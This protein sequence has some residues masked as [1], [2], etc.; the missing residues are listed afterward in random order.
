MRRPL[1]ALGLAILAA[2]GKDATP[3]SP[4]GSVTLAH[5]TATLVPTATLQLTPTVKDI[6]GNVIT[7]ALN[8]TSS[9][10]SLATVSAEGLVRAFS[11]GIVTITATSESKSA[12]LQVT[13]K[14]G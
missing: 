14:D 2:C 11:T 3:P 13:I 10:T 8:Y 1:L 5:D 12:S 4:V 7:R 6:S 9:N